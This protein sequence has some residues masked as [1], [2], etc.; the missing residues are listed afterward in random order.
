MDLR[1]RLNALHRS[2]GRPAPSGPAG[3]AALASPRGSEAQTFEA[4]RAREILSDRSPAAA[5]VLTARQDRS[6]RAADHAESAVDGFAGKSIPAPSES[7]VV[8]PRRPTLDELRARIARM[9]AGRPPALPDRHGDEALIEAVEGEPLVPGVIA[10]RRGHRLAGKHGR[11]AFDRLSDVDLS[12]L[13][14]APGTRLDQLA[15]IDTETSGLSGGSGTIP[16]LTGVA[17]IRGDEILVTQYFLTRFGAEPAMLEALTRDLADVRYLVSFNGK[18]FDVP[19]LVTRYRLARM[20]DPLTGCPHVDLLH[21]TRRA[22]ARHWSDCRLQ[23][24]ERE[25]FG[26]ARIDDIPGADI[27]AVWF[28]Y[29]RRGHIGRAPA[30]VSHNRLDILSLVALLSVLAEAID[31]PGTHGSDV[32]SL[33]RAYRKRGEPERCLRALESQRDY[34]DPRGLLEL[35]REKRRQGAWEDARTIWNDLAGRGHLEAV[36]ALA[37]YHEHVAKDYS[38]A[39]ACVETLLRA[40]PAVQAHA[41]RLARLRRKAARAG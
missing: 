13:D 2:V 15:F 26:L 41:Q 11:I 25:L 4:P 14:V 24:A 17:R 34:L 5:S 23:T 21:P 22:F 6:D 30:V 39:L 29:M 8:P 12:V 16:F 18:C 28:D 40:T 9:Q 1:Q 10:V 35:A 36:E 38:A 37:K 32:V 3:D 33:A 31:V 7:D 19:L 27:P 20:A